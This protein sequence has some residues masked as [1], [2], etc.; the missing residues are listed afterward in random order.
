MGPTISIMKNRTDLFASTICAKWGEDR[1]I[2][3]TASARY[4][5]R[6]S[7]LVLARPK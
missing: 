7:G 5:Y 6:V 4:Y 2:R 3:L 1:L